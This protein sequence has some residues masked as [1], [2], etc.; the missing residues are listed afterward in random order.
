MSEA[1]GL[2][3]HL[4]SPHI[5]GDIRSS[6]RRNQFVFIYAPVVP[7]AAV[8]RP[9]V[10]TGPSYK[11]R[12]ST[13]DAEA[14]CLDYNI[15]PTPRTR[16]RRPRQRYTSLSSPFVA[17][18]RTWLT[19]HW[20]STGALRPA[21]DEPPAAWP[22]RFAPRDVPCAKHAHRDEARD[23]S[24][25]RRCPRYRARRVLVSSGLRPKRPFPKEIHCRSLHCTSTL[26]NC[27]PPTSA[28]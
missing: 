24:R 25:N 7:S 26:P 15:A 4:H 17:A 11:F 14:K 1:P 8:A 28:P 22:A 3:V 6:S 19:L 16:R 13:R 9:R 12:S 27:S 10:P 18:R 21:V 20:A 5:I 23:I 2:V